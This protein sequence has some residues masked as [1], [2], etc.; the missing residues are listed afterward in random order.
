MVTFTF[1]LSE[2]VP[3]LE[4]ERY[5]EIWHLYS[6]KKTISVLG[7]FEFVHTFPSIMEPTDPPIIQHDAYDIVIVGAVLLLEAGEGSNQDERV[8]I[9]ALFGLLMGDPEFDWKYISEAQVILILNS[10][11]KYRTLEERHH[12][13]LRRLPLRRNTIQIHLTHDRITHRSDRH[14]LSRS[15]PVLS[16]E[17]GPQRDICP[18]RSCKLHFYASYVV[19]SLLTRTCSH[20][21]PPSIDFKYMPHPLDGEIYGRHMMFHDALVRT[22]PLESLLKPNGKR[23]PL[24]KDSTTLENAIELIR[25]STM[26]N[27]H[28]CGTCSMMREDLGGVVNGRLRVY[29]TRNVRV[30]DASVIPVIPRGN[31]ITSVYALAEKAADMIKED[32][33]NQPEYLNVPRSPMIIVAHR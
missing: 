20:Q 9:P 17:I 3:L 19:V 25:S 32:L 1:A 23:L 8:E 7:C 28:P 30:V 16:R 10:A 26:T 11:S 21:D 33:A 13:V 18:H 29:G 2:R 4:R 12:G 22:E 5:L 24:G 27:Y 15:S 31:I 6:A 14:A